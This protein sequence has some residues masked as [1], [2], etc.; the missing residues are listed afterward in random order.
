MNASATKT[1]E[2]RTVLRGDLALSKSLSL[3]DPARTA[4]CH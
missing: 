2:Q 3:P 1:L 4:V